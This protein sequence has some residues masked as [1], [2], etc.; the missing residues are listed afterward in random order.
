[1]GGGPGPQTS[2]MQP[3]MF[4][5][6]A[7]PPGSFAGRFPLNPPQAQAF[8][9]QPQQQPGF[10]QQPP[11]PR[12]Q[13]Q[14]RQPPT[15]A[16]QE[17]Q[18]T[19]QDMMVLQQT[20]VGW[21]TPQQLMQRIQQADP[22][23]DPI[24]KW[25]AFQSGMKLL[26]AGGQGQAMQLLNYLQR[27]RHQEQ[28]ERRQQEREEQTQTRTGLMQFRQDPERTALQPALNLLEKRDATIA[29]FTNTA[30]RMGKEVISLGNKISSSGMPAWQAFV[31][32]VKGWEGDPVVSAY[33]LQLQGW[34]AEMAKI[35]GG[36]PTAAV[37]TEGARTEANN[38]LAAE[39]TT[40]KQAQGVLT[41]FER[42][43]RIRKEEVDKQRTKIL[44]R[45]RTIENA[46][47]TGAPVPE[48]TGEDLTPDPWPEVGGDT[49]P[50]AAAPGTAPGWGGFKVKGTGQ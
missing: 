16:Q 46:Y 33:A 35:L 43:A 30:V 9:P 34:K 14:Q 7:S 22:N 11:Q 19:Q 23:A 38:F 48:R 32:K 10:P 21:L 44:D 2:Q 4:P 28:T 8:A 29:E 50:G 24:V 18:P 13:P 20:G 36:S 25:K 5:P 31:Q 41:Q 40:V 15:Q 1:M 26:N 3:G 17:S 47:K 27:E 12:P 42:D 45:L 37:L 39:G 49:A 6:Q